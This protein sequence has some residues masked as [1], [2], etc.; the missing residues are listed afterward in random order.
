MSSLNS[1][2]L[3]VATLNGARVGEVIV[4]IGL[5]SHKSK[6]LTIVSKMQA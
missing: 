5:R 1:A 2:H 4:Q 6:H 3:A